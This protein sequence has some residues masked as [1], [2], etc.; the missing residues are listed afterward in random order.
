MGATSSID[1]ISEETCGL[2]DA[3]HS[4]YGLPGFSTSPSDQ[5]HLTFVPG[6]SRNRYPHGAFL[7][8]WVNPAL[9]IK[10]E[11]G[12]KGLGKL[13][14]PNIISHI[15]G[16]QY[17]QEVYQLVVQPLLDAGISPNFV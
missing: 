6:R 15:G 17:E 9:S 2:S 3:V 10:T 4:L 16:L 14:K 5:W 12:D 13:M 11:N 8:W 1:D 7:K